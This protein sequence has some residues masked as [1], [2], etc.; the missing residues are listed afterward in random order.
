MHV[1]HITRPIIHTTGVVTLKSVVECSINVAD[2]RVPVG[3][4]EVNSVSN[5]VRLSGLSEGNQ[6]SVS[7][8]D[9][10]YDDDDDDN[11][12][13]EKSEQTEQGQYRG[14]HY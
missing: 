10:L 8:S 6:S 5:L 4:M 12:D 14:R 3:R 9:V 2:T 7:L 13:D 11:D 1:K